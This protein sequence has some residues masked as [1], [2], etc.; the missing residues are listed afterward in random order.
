MGWAAD[1]SG[2]IQAVK[3]VHK[4]G[5]GHA[6]AIAAV[7]M[8]EKAEASDLPVLLAA[9]DDANPLAL[10]W[11][12]GAYETIA[13]RKGVQLPTEALTKF[14]NDRSH[15][16]Q[17][18]RL[19]YD[20]LKS[21][22]P[23]LEDRLIPTL[24]DDPSGELRRDA[25]TYT[26]QAAEKLAADGKKDDAR[27][28]YT[29]ALAG[30]VDEDQVKKLAEVL[31]SFDQKVN[32]V[33]H[34]G[35]LTQWKL[36]GPFDNKDKKGF[37]VAHPPETELAFDKEY[38]GIPGPDGK[39]L[40]VQWKALASEDEMGLFDVNKLFEKHMGAT[41]YTTTEF[42]SATAQAVE[43]R[44]GTS[45]A[46]KLWLNGEQLFAREEYHRGMFLDQYLVRGKLKAGKNTLLLKLLQNEQTEDWAQ[47][48]SFQFRVTDFSGRAIHPSKPV[49]TK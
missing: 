16:P 46:W 13:S 9:M 33:E 24:L 12:R 3:A 38:D 30:A 44:L 49:A 6:E 19:A 8:I 4:N 41:V 15:L 34:Y 5:Q 1:L 10:N 32:L 28:K 36:I 27:Q 23:G 40:K 17:A 20:T 45:N 35:F 42:E 21:V 22:D 18:R 2:P 39:P 29:A 48:W 43:F 25:V 14:L 11:L 31:K 47:D 26:M 37:D 7:R